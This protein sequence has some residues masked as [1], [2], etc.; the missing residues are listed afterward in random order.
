M[1]SY[2]KSSLIAL[3]SV[4][5]TSVALTAECPNLKGAYRCG[6]GPSEGG[7]NIDQFINEDGLPIFALMSSKG[8][9]EYIVDGKPHTRLQ[10]AEKI[11]YVIS[12]DEKTL[13][14]SISNPI[15]VV[16]SFTK[17]EGGLEFSVKY[18]V[19]PEMKPLLDQQYEI[20]LA[21]DKPHDEEMKKKL[22]QEIKTVH[23]NLRTMAALITK[24]DELIDIPQYQVSCV[25]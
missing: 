22:V 10:D 24:D 13:N 6:H 4:F 1:N 17:I 25:E 16:A 11:D 20:F 8:W 18:R 2:L 15:T 14:M 9:A 12:C 7:K 23:D 19:I 3:I 21:M 5:F